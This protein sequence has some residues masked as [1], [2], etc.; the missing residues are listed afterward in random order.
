MV[1]Q[2]ACP[3]LL[4]SA[5]AL[6][7]HLR[8]TTHEKQMKASQPWCVQIDFPTNGSRRSITGGGGVQDWSTHA[9]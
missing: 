1:A 9:H 8:L 7:V 2:G 3:Q 5:M 4:T 6:I